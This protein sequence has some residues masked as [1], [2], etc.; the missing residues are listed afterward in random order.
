MEIG[1]WLENGNWKIEI[2]KP[3]LET[4]NWKIE[5]GNLA[6]MFATGNCMKRL[7]LNI[8]VCVGCVL[9]AASAGAR[10]DLFVPAS[11]ISFRIST[12]Q[13]SYGINETV[14]LN[15]EIKNLSKVALYVP[16]EWEATCPPVPHIWVWFLDS[17]G[18]HLTAGYGGDCNPEK[19]PI[20]ERMSKEAV[21]LEPGESTYGPLRLEPA[22]FHLTPGRYRIEGSLTG[23]TPTKFSAEERGELEKMGHPFVTGEVPHSLT[24]V[25]TGELPD[26]PMDHPM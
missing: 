10:D 21:L 23:W 8:F 12:E 16:L 5:I 11:A 4:R 24:V 17:S 3:R 15:Y 14:R 19:K 1:K 2:G 22:M 13:R 7:A 18:N 26:H 25:L 20:Q 9:L 6:T